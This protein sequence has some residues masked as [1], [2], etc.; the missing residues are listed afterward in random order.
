MLG[1]AFENTVTTI[2][3]F[4][5]IHRIRSKSVYAGNHCS[6]NNIDVTRRAYFEAT[7]QF[8]YF[9]FD[10]TDATDRAFFENAVEIHEIT[11]EE[12]FEIIA[13]F[14]NLERCHSLHGLTVAVRRP[15]RI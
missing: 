2:L 1:W 14:N 4:F 5:R 11:F 3:P 13:Q 7:G 9:L 15:M 6:S 12:A 10:I 8:T